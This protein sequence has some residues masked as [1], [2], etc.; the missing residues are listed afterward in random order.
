MC[1][2]EKSK[3]KLKKNFTVME[4]NAAISFLDVVGSSRFILEMYG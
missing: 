1:L 4:Y 3:K 2:S